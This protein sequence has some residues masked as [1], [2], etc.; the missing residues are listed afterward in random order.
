[1]REHHVGD[2]P[3]E[4]AVE[5]AVTTQDQDDEHRR[6]AVEAEGAEVDVGVGLRPD[7]ARDASDRRREGIAGDEPRAHRGTDGMHAQGILADSGQ[8]LAEGRIDQR[9][10]EREA[11]EEHD[12]DVEILRRRKQ[13]TELEHPEERSDGQAVEAVEAAGVG[14][15]E[16]SRFLEQGHGA[17]GQ[18]EQGETLR[19]Q[20]HQTRAETDGRGHQGRE[21]QPGDG[22]VPDSVLGEH[23][24]GI[25]A[26]PEERG[27]PEG[28][29]PR[30]A[31]HEVERESKEDRDQEFGAKAEMS[32]EG[33]I[34]RGGQDPRDRLPGPEP[35]PAGQDARGRMIGPRGLRRGHVVLPP[36]RP[37]GRQSKSKMVS[38]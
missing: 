5:T 18:H 30:I 38:A 31:E 21:D 26:G 17:Q 35:V 29:D 12:E 20:Q 13:R 8:T 14:M 24:H 9:A 10:H 3:D 23:T 25:G 34:E 6:R 32:W 37:C 27:M 7:A 28:H 19:A 16:I 22:L 11:E 2:G 36:N 1:V 4:G 15:T 33:E